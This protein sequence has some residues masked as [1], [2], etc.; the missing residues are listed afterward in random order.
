[1]ILVTL[2]VAGAIAGVA[3]FAIALA[4]HNRVSQVVQ[5]CA[6]VLRRQL[7]VANGAADRLCAARDSARGRR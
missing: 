1:V 5:E 2:A 4:A 3:G 7:Q 6:D